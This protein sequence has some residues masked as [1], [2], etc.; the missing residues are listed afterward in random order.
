MMNFDRYR[1]HGNLVRADGRIER[2]TVTVSDGLIS[3]VEREDFPREDPSRP[4]LATSAESYVGPGLIDL[5]MHGAIGEEFMAADTDGVHKIL[6]FAAQHGVTGLLASAAAAAND[7]ISAALRTVGK[8]VADQSRSVLYGQPLAGAR[9]LGAHLEGPYLSQ[10]RRGGQDPAAIR[11]ADSAEFHQWT[12]LA[13]VRMIT[14]APEEAGVADLIEF[15]SQ[16][17]P[18]VILAAGHTDATYEQALDG[19][20]A[21]ITHFTH[22]MCGMSGFHHRQPGAVGA[23]LT[24]SSATV[25]LIADLIHVHPAALALVV[26]AR[27]AANVALVTDSVKF[28]GMPDGRYTKRGRDYLVADGSVRLPDGTLAGSRLTMN[29]AVRNMASIGFGAGAAWQMAS[30]VP[31]TILGIDSQAGL[32]APGRDA[33]ITVLDGDFLPECTIVGGY[34]VYDRTHRTEQSRLARVQ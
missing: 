2:G 3:T 5:H 15:I 4:V 29:I 27:G 33:D 23:G 1:I 16:H 7:E 26:T 22:F 12:Q 13:P 28:C 18:D 17:H 9:L 24:G 30:A 8:V 34:P 31:A 20:A 14:V 10:K 6:A 21:G 11:R 19:I 32:L 25:E